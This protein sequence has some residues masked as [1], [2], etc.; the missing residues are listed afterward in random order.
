[1]DAKGLF[2]KV[3]NLLTLSSFLLWNFA[4]ALPEGGSV[5][6]GSAQ[7]SQAG[8]QTTINQTSQNTVI[9]WHGF[10]T[11][12]TESVKFNQPNSSSIALNR[13]NSGQPTNFNGSLSAN[14]QVWLLNPSGVLFGST[15]KIDVAGLLVTTHNI[16]DSNFM[17]GN[18]V[19]TFDPNFSNSKIINNGLISV[20]DSGIV[21]LVGPGV[22]NNGIIQANLGKVY[23]SS[24]AAFVLDM[25]GDSLINFGSSPAVQNGYV[26]NTGTITAT[27]G[28]VY[29]TANSAAGVLDNV[30]SMSGTIQA[31][32]AST[33]AHGQIIL[34]GGHAGTV[35]VSGKL[36][37]SSGGKIET[38][39]YNLDLT[40]ADINA[41]IGG[42]WLLD[43]PVI[44]TSTWNGLIST[45]LN[46]GTN[47]TLST[48]ISGLGAGD[49]YVDAPITWG[50]SAVLMLGAFRNI[51][52]SAPVT[53]SNNGGFI[54][55]A[56]L[57]AN[58]T[59]TV[60][61]SGSGSVTVNGA[62]GYAKLFYNPSSYAT[63]TDY[64]A[65]LLG[66]APVKAGYMMIN[67]VADLQ[68]A[69]AGFTSSASD[70]YSFNTDI[71]GSVFANSIF[72]G[73]FPGSIDGHD[74]ATGLNHVIYNLNMTINVGFNNGALISGTSSGA[75]E[76][77]GMETCLLANCS[78][79]YGAN[80]I[81]VP[82]GGAAFAFSNQGLFSHVF[83]NGVMMGPVN[84]AG[85]AV[86][87]GLFTGASGVIQYSYVM[88]SL[89]ATAT[90]SAYS[91]ALVSNTYSGTI[92]NSFNAASLS[93]NYSIGGIAGAVQ[94][95]GP[96]TTF[97]TNV[98]NV[99][100][101]APA[102]GG[103]SGAIVGHLNGSQTLIVSGAYWDTT[104][105]GVGGACGDC[106][107]ANTPLTDAQMKDSV[108]KS[109][110]FPTFDFVNT[111]TMSG[112]NYPQ[113]KNQNTQVITQTQFAGTLGVAA[114][115]Q[116][117]SIYADNVLAGS[118][119]VNGSGFFAF[120]FNPN[121][122]YSANPN[123]IMATTSGAVKGDYVAKLYGPV[124][125]LDITNNTVTVRSD[126]GAII[127][128]TNITAQTNKNSYTVS[129]NNIN[130]NASTNFLTTAGVVYS[131][132]FTTPNTPYAINGN[133]TYSGTPSNNVTFNGPV[134]VTAA[135]SNIHNAGNTLFVST[136]DGPN[137][138][139][140][141]SAGSVTFNT[142]VGGVAALDSLT[143]TAGTA[144]NFNTGATSVRTN[145]SQT[146]NS[147]VLF[148][149]LA[150]IS[151]IDLNTTFPSAVNFNSTVNRT[152]T[153]TAVTIAGNL[154]V[155]PLGSI[156]LSSVIQSLL[157]NGTTLG[158]NVTTAGS[159]TYVGAVTLNTDETMISTGGNINYNSTVDG[160]FNLTARAMAAGKAVTF[161]G[162]VG[163]TP[164][165]SLTT[166]DN[167][168]LGTT[169]IATTAIT[170]SGNQTYNNAITLG[171]TETLSGTTMTFNGTVNNSLGSG[172]FTVNGGVVSF[173]QAVGNLNPA[174]GTL[175]VSATGNILFGSTLDNLTGSST[176]TE[177]TNGQ[178]ITFTGAVGSLHPITSLAVSN[179]VSPITFQSTIDNV[180]TL[181]L[182][183]GGGSNFN[184]NGKIGSLGP[185]TTLNATSNL[186]GGG[187]PGNITF[188]DTLTG[189]KNLTVVAGGLATFNTTVN[190]TNGNAVYNITGGGVT[191][192]QAVGNLFPTFGL[193]NVTGGNN[194]ILFA[195]TLD[196][197]TGASTMTA[198]AAG[199]VTFT[200]AVG[201]LHPLASLNVNAFVS[202]ITFQ[203]TIDNIPT[204]TLLSGGGSNF[205]FNGKIGSLGPVTTLNATSNLTGGGG[206]GNIT[207]GDTL[208]GLTNLTVSAGGLA[209]FNTTVNNTNGN[210][211][212][213]IT[214][215]GV[216]FNQAVG[217][218]FPTF[219]LLNVT[220]GN[221]NILF[222]STLDGLTGASTI[223]DNFSGSITFAGA[224]GS[225]HPLAS[226]NVN[227]FVSPITFQSTI[228]NIPTLTL[229]S[230]GGSNFNFNGKIGSLGPVT[231]LNATSNLTGGGGP[232]NIT[233]GNTL[234]GL[235]NL[236]VTAGGSAI[237][238]TTVDN[239]NGN[240]VY[241]IT[242][243][244][245]ATGGGVA[246]NQAVGSLFPTFGQLTVSAKGGGNALFASTLDGL[247]GAST[248]T[249][250]S[251][252]SITFT[253]AVGSL[254]PLA[255]LTASA[256]VSPIT[257]Q[258]TIDNITGALTLTS[259]GGS[260][261]NFNGKIG[262]LFSVGS[263]SAT[264]NPT[265]GGGP[266][267][268]TFGDTINNLNTLVAITFSTININSASIN[269]TTSQ[270]YTG[271]VN[272]GV[273]N[274]NLSTGAGGTITFNNTVNGTSNLTVNTTPTGTV[275]FN[276]S[277]GNSIALSSLSV[278]SGS[279][280]NM[281]TG[282]INTTGA[283]TFTGPVT[284]SVSAIFNS[285]SGT[286]L[287]KFANTIVG[288][289]V[290]RALTVQSGA[291][292][293][294]EFDAAIGTNAIPFTAL[295]LTGNTTYM[296]GVG[297]TVFVSGAELYTNNLVLNNLS[298]LTLNG[299]S[300]TFNGAVTST[301]S[302]TALTIPGNLIVSS[303]GS[304]GQG[305][306]AALDALTVTGTTN[307][308]N[309]VT[310]IHNQL[311]N[312]AYT[313]S[314]NSILTS[315]LGGITFNTS[316]AADTNGTRDLTLIAALPVAIGGNWNPANKLHTLTIGSGLVATPATISSA[317]ITT[318]NGMRFYGP[319][320]ITTN[321]KKFTSAAGTIEFDQ[322]ISGPAFT[323][324][325]DPA[326][327]VLAGTYNVASLTVSATSEID[328]QQVTATTSGGES[329]T[330][331]AIKLQVGNTSLTDS[332]SSIA[333]NGAIDGGFA[334]S[335]ST[336]GA[337]K[338][339]FNGVVGG[340]TPLASVSV[341]GIANL[342]T[343][344]TVLIPSV[345][346]S[347]SQQ[348]SGAVV[349]GAD[350][351]LT[352]SA[353]NI[354]FS[355]TVN[356]AFGLTTNV[357]S[358]N[359]VTFSGTV[360]NAPALTFVTTNGT[361]NTN[362]NG[363][364]VITTGAQNYNNHVF[365][366]AA[367]TL[368]STGGGVLNFAAIDSNGAP[369]RALT[370]TT[371]A[372]TTLNGDIGFG[373]G[374][375]SMLTITGASN[376]ATALIG[377]TISQTYTGA[378]TLSAATI[379]LDTS[380]G[381]SISFGSTV[382]GASVLTLDATTTG[383]VTFNN[384][385]GNAIPLTVLTTLSPTI[386]NVNATSIKTATTQSYG[387][388]V[389]LSP[390]TATFIGTTVTF[391]D[392]VTGL[393][394]AINIGINPTN[395]TNL[396]TLQITAKSLLV[397]G[398]SAIGG[399][400]TTTNGQEYMGNVNV[401]ANETYSDSSVNGI[402]FD[403][404]LS[405][406][407]FIPYILN[408]NESVGAVTFGG[409]VGALGINPF[410]SLTVTGA[411]GI[412]INGGIIKTV[413]NQL[414]NNAVILGVQAA[415]LTS[416]AG[417]ITFGS[418]LDGGF[419]LSLNVP[420]AGSAI[421]FNGM[422]GNT[423]PLASLTASG[424][425]IF[426]TTLVK[427]SGQQTYNNPVTV[428]NSTN[429][430]NFN[431]WSMSSANITFKDYLTAGSVLPTNLVNILITGNFVLAGPNGN[432]QTNLGGGT[433][434][435]SLHVTGTSTFSNPN[436][437]N[438][439]AILNSILFDGPVI[440]SA[441]NVLFAVQ[442]PGSVITFGSTL[443]SSGGPWT[444]RIGLGSSTSVLNLNGIV[445]GVGGS[446]PLNALNILGVAGS[447]IN[448]NTSEIN[449]TGL[450][451]YTGNV[452]LGSD[453]T[454]TSTAGGITFLSTVNSDTL[455][456]ARALT[457]T[458]PLVTT[459]TGNIGSLVK[460]KSLTITNASDIKTAAISTTT[461]QTYGGAVTLDNIPAISFIGTDI[462][463][464]SPVDS[465]TQSTAITI[466]QIAPLITTNLIV[467]TSGSIG[468]N[469]AAPGNVHVGSI[470]VSG[471]T[472]GPNTNTSGNQTYSGP[473]TLNTDETMTSTA[474]NIT[475]GSTVN[476]DGVLDRTLIIS[477]NNVIFNGVVGGTN[478]LASLSVT[479]TGA[480]VNAN[481]ISTSGV[482]NYN[483]THVVMGLAGLTTL[484]A[485]TVNIG[486]Y[487]DS[488][489]SNSD[490]TINGNLVLNAPSGNISTT[491]NLFNNII[492]NGSTTVNAGTPTPIS[493]TQNL[494][495]NG[496]ITILGIQPA[497]FAVTGTG[498]LTV[499]GTINGPGPL[500]LSTGGV[501]TINVIGAVGGTT[502][503]SSLQIAGSGGTPS[504]A[505]I[506]V[507]VINTVNDQT[508][509]NTALVLDSNTTL[510]STAG[511]VTFGST[512]DGGFNLAVSAANAAKRVT[513]NGMVG[514]TTPLA[515]LSVTSGDYT[516]INTTLIKTVGS[517]TYSGAVVIEN[518][519]NPTNFNFWSTSTS[520]ISFN[521]YL[522]SS[523]LSL[524]PVNVLITGNFV[525]AAP[526]GNLQQTLGNSSQQLNSLHV[527]G[528]STFSNPNVLNGVNV[529]GS[530]TYDGAVILNVDQV[531]FATQLAGGV[532]TFGSTIQSNGGPWSIFVALNDAT[533]ILN[534]N[535]IVGGIGGTNP[536]NNLTIVGSSAATTNIN[537]TQIN[538]TGTQSYGSKVVLGADTTLTSTTAGL[539]FSSTVNSNG[540]PRSL[541]L[542]AFNP[543]VL[544]GN[545]GTGVGG[546]LSTLHIINEADINTATISTTTSQ[547]YD[548]IVKL[549]SPTVT[550]NTNAGGVVTFGGAVNATTSG[551]QSLVVNATPTGTVSF[552]GM[553]GN[554]TALNNLTVTAAQINVNNALSPLSLF[555]IRTAGSQTYTGNMVFGRG[556]A[557]TDNILRFNN[558][559]TINGTINGSA[560]NADEVDLFESAPGGTV[561]LNGNVGNI[562]PLSILYVATDTLDFNAT[563]I[564][565]VQWE[566]YI[567]E[568]VFSQNNVT[569]TNDLNGPG[570]GSFTTNGIFFDQDINSPS[571]NLVLNSDVYFG[572]FGAQSNPANFNS[573]ASLTVG[574]NSNSFLTAYVQNNTM[575]TSGNQ[576]YN[577]QM[578]LVN[579]N[580][581]APV[582]LTSSGGTIT[583]NGPVASDTGY[584]V[585]APVDL[586]LNGT[587]V[588]NADL[589]A[590]PIAGGLFAAGR[591]GTLNSLTVTGLTI[592]NT[593][594]INTLN[595]Q[596]FNQA[597]TLGANST[598]T[599][600]AGSIT[601]GSTVDSDT[602]VVAN[603]R[604]L[605]L[606]SPL[607][608]SLSGNIG[609]INQLKSL[610][611]G[612]G[613]V[614]T[615]ASI[616]TA[617][618]TTT[619]AQTYYGPV[620][621]QSL[622]AINFTHTDLTF[623]NA[624]TFNNT[625]NSVGVPTAI[626]II[627]NLAVG[628]SGSIGLQFAA[629]GN[630]HVA[631]IYVTGTTLGP[632]TNTSGNQTYAG[633]L[634]L[635]TDETMTSTAGN[636]TFG[637]T[638]DGDGVLDRALVLSANNVTFNGVVGG[639]NPLASLMV[640]VP[641]G[642]FIEFNTTLVKTV[643][644]QTYSG[645][646]LI[647]DPTN[648]SAINFWS[649]STST[650]S[651][652]SAVK[653]GGPSATN[654]IDITITGNFLL[655]GPNGN[656][657]TNAFTGPVNSLH[658]T[659][660]ST[661]S[662]PNSFNG[663]RTLSSQTYDGPVI[664][665]ADNVGFATQNV[666][667]IITFGSTLQS[668]GGPWSALMQ[669]SVLNFNGIV[670]G[671]GGT[672]PLNNLTVISDPAALTNINTTEIN[673]TGTQSYGTPVILGSNTTLTSTTAGITFSSTVDSDG[674]PRSLTLNAFNPTVLTGNIG[675]S[676]I[677]SS[678]EIV[679]EADINTGSIK[680]T[681]AQLYDGPVV[682]NSST[683]L[684][685]TN[686]SGVI[687]FGD[688]LNGAKDLILNAT[689]TGTVT[690]SGIVGGTTP[691]SSITVLNGTTAIDTTAITTT[692]S[693]SYNDILLNSDATL[694]VGP[695]NAQL[696]LG[697]ITGPYALVLQDGIPS[698]VFFNGDVN[699]YS[700][701]VIFS[702][703]FINTA[704][705]NTTSFQTYQGAVTLTTDVTMT[706]ATDGI[707]FLSTV[708]SDGTPRALT[709]D[710]FLPTVL[711][712]NIGN[713]FGG[714]LSTLE[715]IN[716]ADIN[717]PI[718]KTTT[719]QLYDGIVKVGANTVLTT[720]NAGG[721]I[722]F[723]NILNGD[724]NILGP[725]DLAVNSDTVKFKNVIGGNNPLNNLS[726]NA[727]IINFDN[728]S[729]AITTLGT[730]TYTGTGVNPLMTIGLDPVFTAPSFV[731]AIPLAILAD[732]T[733][734][735]TLGN[736]DFQ[737]TIDGPA[738][739]ILNPNGAA[740]F[741]ADVGNTTPLASLTVNGDT[742]IS[743]ASVIRT[744]GDQI[745]SN[746]MTLNNNLSTTALTTGAIQ[747]GNQ[748]V[749]TSG[750][751]GAGFNLI[752][753]TNNAANGPTGSGII[754][755]VR[756][757]NFT[758]GGPGGANLSFNYP[759][760][761][762]FV[763]GQGAGQ[764]FVNTVISPDFRPAAIYCVNNFCALIPP[765]PTPTPTPTPDNV[766][767]TQ[768]FN[769][770]TVVSCD[771]AGCGNLEVV[772]DNL[773]E[774]G[775]VSC[776]G[777][778][779]GEYG[780][781]YGFVEAKDTNGHSRILM[782]G[783]VVYAGD[784]ISKNT[785]SCMCI[786]SIYSKKKT[787]M[788]AG[789]TKAVYD[790]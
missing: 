589:G 160:A 721:Q 27:G 775:V 659:G 4:A 461:F 725:W 556:G 762:S 383:S 115:G 84:V 268:I 738:N 555:R 497:L 75:I 141:N 586:V 169:T 494:T 786:K 633:A 288:S 165:A 765:T 351:V 100:L 121:T 197:L 91:G 319:V 484:T 412:N 424:G 202:P 50:T 530:Q 551:A 784:Q 334:L 5:A 456:T 300:V 259:N 448:I 218:L 547:L 64:S 221:N 24:G 276:S 590:N 741:E 672:N 69:A 397:T 161:S 439:L 552:N 271:L 26:S 696:N 482:Q 331:P 509:T 558:T 369:P 679:H 320:T 112:T 723:A 34:N 297:P 442:N 13:I 310:T 80:V 298:S 730:Q 446:N 660:M 143:V 674:T 458:S 265:G 242:G 92:S 666:G 593:A 438:G 538:T 572:F 618:I 217:N 302:A 692:F 314:G 566:E 62:N 771:A 713:S 41:G 344:G 512:V 81:N 209:T 304:V 43:P 526:N 233:F 667:G 647:D 106:A 127:S 688:T 284:D 770:P 465:K 341:T 527:T 53:A 98:Y 648:P 749:P 381:G 541:T 668:S 707:N 429:P 145:N 565:T 715:I 476:G 301:G 135:S 678:L 113:L 772:I 176:I 277:I 779:S 697:S 149:S 214:G 254:H 343:A 657:Q 77:L 507:G 101:I 70:S 431:F 468:L 483:A 257:F 154:Q 252:A 752:A 120:N 768:I 74:Y 513:F 675:N 403:G 109:I 783:D 550:L 710:A 453:T 227:A 239:A 362:I 195:S 763:I 407:A 616:S 426:N 104:T 162:I 680:T 441:D 755:I 357:T 736:I 474:G 582:T 687:T 665:A 379:N 232:G 625:V 440:L 22:E 781:A 193:L 56:D 641:V 506:N 345:L 415:A 261:F 224:V 35:K 756:V 704:N 311:Y 727:N 536:L 511:N 584:G 114:A 142:I 684:S 750:V 532:I 94:N 367:T 449:T 44:Y 774:A 778:A 583:F 18:Y 664:L 19:F 418:T 371:G 523:L 285:T 739:L 272:L 673:T 698:G 726:V 745:Y 340:I 642:N 452:I 204:L 306:G 434:I 430:T 622:G 72:V 422:V 152:V 788:G 716:E 767:P 694:T 634:T 605:T 30:I 46:S 561:I 1:M 73:N 208:T 734:T 390:A 215:G 294:I 499:N 54:A 166:N 66:S 187:G 150:S 229:L 602:P 743:G 124:G 761:E 339:I 206:P 570:N 606:V 498:T 220:G 457:L 600:T 705:I 163:G 711:T 646:V 147:P 16:T 510:T 366:N 373:G 7:I 8:A 191:F 196:G 619:T 610:T 404:L 102:S 436:I 324:N 173:N 295:T 690:F 508:Y 117:V 308:A 93:G 222:A 700:L 543:T 612:S 33:G 329:F 130:L 780:C 108:N 385:V 747:F 773:E 21:A 613:L 651:F 490:L 32:T 479:A 52:I 454:L 358:P 588:A 90:N 266:G 387:N 604:D 701:D 409:A 391:N 603:A 57:S 116:T 230:G 118:A 377:T 735:S 153:S 522:A 389:M 489:V 487:I 655:A 576:T 444:A 682:L 235:K 731:I 184:F 451:T 37:A 264:S 722:I 11:A 253:G 656:L 764:A 88:G 370:L 414:F 544:T 188:G 42:T 562:T 378:V 110:N 505:N 177:T 624:I 282:T 759:T 653:G 241:N 361:G 569:I 374:L 322:G 269:T 733:Y 342:N 200:G 10:D 416:T 564:H 729:T 717:T 226:L 299:T 471:T 309:N 156:G 388:T 744:N 724:G 180:T 702:N 693:Q 467:G 493:A 97:L 516:D 712:G 709:L 790:K 85:L 36:N 518:P 623:P 263:V 419:N 223:T 317:N 316:V 427:T 360:G 17:S 663:V 596:L 455:P 347:G 315:T 435:N 325:I 249:A 574:N 129:G 546:I 421:F 766:P 402:K 296:S 246:F 686:A 645:D 274:T 318:T 599:S 172:T 691:L 528:T 477:G 201:S 87:N 146:Y 400:I 573:L 386:F 737:S 740:I 577:G 293:N 199:A 338:T 462:T 503:L 488:G 245:P 250:T 410:D 267:I 670:G 640:T 579:F 399:N 699:I 650:V 303:T 776:S 628:P 405:N 139:T 292:G 86:F 291:T 225:L 350:N 491:P 472:L 210:A 578:L 671:T 654:A 31:T 548:G 39:G 71:D 608:V 234:T 326:I 542:N 480:F 685:V 630:V 609:S 748:A 406:S 89:T 333:F 394:T 79:G 460:L 486:S 581:G 186:T 714:I 777:S 248:I 413:N 212:Y 535:G 638:V 332:G 175:I 330:A 689:P 598:L 368:T 185:V 337:N 363:G 398:T 167:A 428:N 517:Q 286:A 591:D 355:N 40:G 178:T 290:G 629:P 183:S 211:V 353:G 159:Q 382:N 540:T 25:Y 695:I 571:T 228:D 782:P 2:K 420:N 637:S 620:L 408:I 615:P 481:L 450:Q 681:T 258:S 643:G 372:L 384:V 23:L 525:L 356:G 365:I 392:V 632:N 501:G 59:G 787:C 757:N 47:V 126:T 213:N 346:T 594:A 348:Y 708:D 496:S 617:S 636:I 443:Q 611:I 466:G 48:G 155:G 502:P 219:G 255:S 181:T 662:N 669:S 447:T 51:N 151:F 380:P 524:N 168:A 105:S 189:L 703:I 203:S 327:V 661:F 753:V 677:L 463:F 45:Q 683:T 194:N 514:S 171:G 174:F 553:V 158:P 728:N 78:T 125:N 676:S 335:T 631:S 607:T 63:P 459:L 470:F 140:I 635:N 587:V 639:V 433:L 423:T 539:N 262:S 96:G 103:L 375:L 134:T 751:F 15:S 531:I 313:V 278:T 157:V 592:I 595:N 281:N 534:F 445:G 207:F 719:A 128:N 12:A 658:V 521:S 575:T 182:L 495:F 107:F 437:S 307:G 560:Y 111:W 190:N 55:R 614:A 720:T 138:L 133:I 545:I 621:F 270:T 273:A 205:N 328:L 504:T 283:Q 247:T 515:T 485:S 475:F 236:N 275:N 6:Q 251:I 148:N 760:A 256:F 529:W 349:L 557:T 746:I 469:F 554:T 305:V 164:L 29:M 3:V 473:L 601:F 136:L 336:S 464:N 95:S 67:S 376:I 289:G 567:A 123:I 58:G 393:G 533:S 585:S 478:P 119:V 769:V 240:A 789:N 563:S 170:T 519:T 758:V 323:V 238:N 192:N 237:F 99:G 260:S 395:I 718:I 68:S 359:A 82:N 417:N 131:S 216:T 649:T 28:K 179:F 144:I 568:V 244:A 38:S 14:G 396:S 60:N 520:D 549:G 644:S 652:N 354:T 137:D 132:V 231:T 500:S 492:I 597:V 61:F 280:I 9:N 401:S 537:T 627:G 312:G 76:N 198:T 122:V 706:S 364:S 432:L 20:L 279:A 742:T 83:F 754:G 65:V 626:T 352:S 580:L 411:A 732:T 243:G 559:L 287:I 49:I 425:V 321:N 785:G